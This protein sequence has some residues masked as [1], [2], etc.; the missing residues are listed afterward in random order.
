MEELWKDIP[1]FEG[2]YQASN[3][4]NIRSLDRGC[5]Y[6]NTGD[7][8]L[9]KGKQLSGKTTNKGYKEV[10]LMVNGKHFYKR[11]HQLVALTFIPNPNNYPHINHINENK[12][13]NRVENLEW[14]T[15]QLNMD[16]YY[17]S[18][19]SVYQYNLSGELL[20]VWNSLTKA[21]KDVNGDKTGIHHCCVGKLSNGNNKKTYLGYIWS[22]TPLN[23]CEL[24]ERMT[25]NNLKGVQQFDLDGNLLHTY[26][27]MTEAAKAV[28]CNSSAI[29]MAC[30]GLRNTIKGYIWK[31]N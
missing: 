27:S 26:K 25:D 21:A 10:V 15:P 11:V 16:A 12:L 31:K 2:W 29:S 3:L 30:S 18:R 1:G 17:E 7:T 24:K 19:I 22:Y 8:A 20:K 9:H 4:G 5:N 6:K 14:C 28:H 13:D 23:K